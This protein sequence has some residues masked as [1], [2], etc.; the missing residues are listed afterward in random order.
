[1]VPLFVR[2]FEERIEFLRKFITFLGDSVLRFVKIATN[3][4]ADTERRP[5]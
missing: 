2:P 4:S 3:V 5:R 1:V